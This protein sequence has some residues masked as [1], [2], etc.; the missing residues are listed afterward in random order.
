MFPHDLSSFF[1]YTVTLHI[2]RHVSKSIRVGKLIK[3]LTGW[4]LKHSFNACHPE[5]FNTYI[6]TQ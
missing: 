3:G 6:N 1:S 4:V 5:V 2:C